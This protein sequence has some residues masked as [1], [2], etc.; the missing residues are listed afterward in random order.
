MTTR[1]MA[2]GNTPPPP[3]ANEPFLHLDPSKV[4]DMQRLI[5][6]GLIWSPVIA[7]EFKQW[8]ATGL[9]DGTYEATPTALLHIA[10][11]PGLL[12]HINDLRNPPI[13]PEPVT[14]EPKP[15]S[16]DGTA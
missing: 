10:K 2:P 5:D 3:Q 6:S 13:T 9:A 14:P 16:T 12:A 11:Q 7:R 1:K 4:A 8:A 15:G